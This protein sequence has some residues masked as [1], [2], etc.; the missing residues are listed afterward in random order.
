MPV[1]GGSNLNFADILT[2]QI[3]ETDFLVLVFARFDETVTTAD[4]LERDAPA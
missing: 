1:V 2:A 4:L 3:P